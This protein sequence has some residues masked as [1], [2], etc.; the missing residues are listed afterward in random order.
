MSTPR[1][2]YADN[3]PPFA[4]EPEGQQNLRR[5]KLVTWV[6]LAC[7]VGLAALKFWVGIVGNS[8]AVIADAVHSLSDLVT[9]V[10][11]LV[12]IG[13]WSAP[14]DEDHPHGHRRIETLCTTLIAVP[15]TWATAPWP[16]FGNRS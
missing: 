1:T 5:L 11:V 7:N 13:I 14:A 12:G 6:G 2:Q 4:E 8:Q 10:A 9:D 15:E 3:K 16:R